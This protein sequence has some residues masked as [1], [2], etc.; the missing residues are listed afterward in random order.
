MLVVSI[1][2]MR[3]KYLFIFK[4]YDFKSHPFLWVIIIFIETTIEY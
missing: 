1:F 4:V 3:K 2:D